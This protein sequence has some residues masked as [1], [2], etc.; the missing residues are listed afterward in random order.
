MKE[1]VTGGP[2]NSNTEI[3]ASN[4][5]PQDWFSDHY[6][7][8]HDAINNGPVDEIPRIVNRAMSHYANDDLGFMFAYGLEML[9]NLAKSFNCR[10]IFDGKVSYD[11]VTILR[12]GKSIRDTLRAFFI[13][14]ATSMYYTLAKFRENPKY[15]LVQRAS[16]IIERDFAR[17]DL[18]LDYVAEK[19]SVSSG[20]LCTIFSE[21][22]G[23]NFKDQVIETRMA[24]AREMLLN[25]E[26]SINQIAKNVGYS[27]A[28]YFSYA[29]RKYFGLTP[30]DYVK[31]V[32]DSTLNDAE[33]G[34]ED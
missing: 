12:E 28:R 25:N 2:N 16:A 4:G 10:Q 20:Y 17:R 19:L 33:N 31:E 8:I 15:D 13:K 34:R 30:R 18:S 22:S 24:H 9:R 29:F 5:I 21:T 3:S 1:S 27:S 6:K 32:V 7:E 11:I 23:K 14:I 26:V